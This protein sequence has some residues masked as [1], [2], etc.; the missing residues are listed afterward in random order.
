MARVTVRVNIPSNP[1]NL[2]T[3]M[4]DV[5]REHVRLAP[6]SPIPVAMATQ[7]E[8][9]IAEAKPKRQLGQDLSRQSQEAFESANTALG[10]A[11]GQTTR[12]PNT[13]LNLVAQIR[14]RLL[15]ANPGSENALELFGFEVVVGTASS[16]KKKSPPP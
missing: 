7:M 9:V 3:L 2:I 12:T 11:A 10:L 14:D 1:D 13:G 8:A 15:A 5:L 6:A 16:P 4:E